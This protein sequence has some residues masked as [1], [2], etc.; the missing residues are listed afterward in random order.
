MNLDKK[1]KY[2]TL[3]WDAISYNE[4][5][6]RVYYIKKQTNVRKIELSLSPTNGFHV[7]VSLYGNSNILLL[8]RAWKDDG[9]RIIHDIFNRPDNL[10]DILWSRKTIDGIVWEEKHLITLTN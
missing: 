9:R 1:A 8:R 7:R 5:L 4:A 10:H 3:D 6:K 2:L